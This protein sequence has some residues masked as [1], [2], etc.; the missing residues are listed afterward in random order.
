MS[1]PEP[2]PSLTA[3]IIRRIRR[4][5]RFIVFI[6]TAGWVFPHVCTEEMDLTAIQQAHASK[7]Q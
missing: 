7:K 5:C 4:V 1:V 2:D 3:T 6:C